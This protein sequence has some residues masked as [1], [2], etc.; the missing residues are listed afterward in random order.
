MNPPNLA[1]YQRKHNCDAATAMR[2]LRL[3]P[4][5]ELPPM[6]GYAPD[7]TVDVTLVYADGNTA[8]GYRDGWTGWMVWRDG[9]PWAIDDEPDDAEQPI[10]WVAAHETASRE[11]DR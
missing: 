3:H 5:D 4:L 2:A 9:L 11:G 1:E 6:A 7:S 8:R 10:G